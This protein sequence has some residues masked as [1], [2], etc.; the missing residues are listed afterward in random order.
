[1][2]FFDRSRKAGYLLF[3]VFCVLVA[4]F[5]L[6]VSTFFISAIRPYTRSLFL[7]TLAAFFLLGMVLMASVVRGKVEGELKKFLILTGASAAGFVALS[8]LHNVFY[9]LSVITS[10]IAVLSY[11]IRV[12]EVMF[13]L[14]AIFVCPLVF[15]I[16]VVGS[17][18]L[19]VN[20]RN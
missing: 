4:A 14:V 3:V 6:L 10:H 20:K 18:V 12:F 15:L 13:F 16:G 1:M 9:G 5:V 2:I 19:F 8:V 11:L 7:Y 17:I